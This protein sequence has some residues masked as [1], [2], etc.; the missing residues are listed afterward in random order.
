[1]F[2]FFPCAIIVKTILIHVIFSC[3]S[4]K[5]TLKDIN[6]KNFYDMNFLL[7]GISS[8]LIF[9]ARSLLQVLR[10]QFWLSLK[11]FTPA[12]KNV[13]DINF[14]ILPTGSMNL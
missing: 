7:I 4:F 3:N 8:F 13:N 11:S 10:E 14:I 1:M 5:C 9:N 12:K 6:Y 2:R